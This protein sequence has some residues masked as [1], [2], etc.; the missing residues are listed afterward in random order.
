MRAV[1]TVRLPLQ[2]GT[3]SLWRAITYALTWVPAIALIV[4]AVRSVDYLEFD[5]LSLVILS[6]AA[7]G[8]ALLVGILW[9]IEV[10]LLRKDA[11]RLRA[12]DAV[13]DRDSVRIVGGVHHGLTL[14]IS[15]PEL[16]DLA[17]ETREEP[18]SQLL[19]ILA[20]RG[21]RRRIDSL[22]IGKDK[23]RRV[24]AEAFDDGERDSLRAL[25]ETILA[26]RATPVRDDRGRRVADEVVRCP[27]CGAAQPA[28]EA[29]EATCAHCGETVRIPDD[30]RGRLAAHRLLP[31]DRA[32]YQAL[33]RKLTSQPG[34]GTVNRITLA[35][36][37]VAVLAWPAVLLAAF[38]LH[39]HGTATADRLALL[40]AAELL[41]V[42]S[43][44]GLVRRLL[45][46]RAAL[47]LFALAYG[48]AP[49]PAPD[50]PPGCRHCAAPLA[51]GAGTSIARCGYCG[52]DNILGIDLRPIADPLR[53][54]RTTLEEAAAT[55]RRERARWTAVA[56]AS[57]AGVAAAAGA[58]LLALR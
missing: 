2:V 39:H 18:R 29:A 26:V 49:P 50:S 38:Y 7:R 34:A 23:D 21:G 16:A 1:S 58:L 12:S 33:I 56:L 13:I 25:H 41:A 43:L 19:Y 44:A 31:A 22:V 48:A 47:R 17:I 5:A 35:V 40:A 9:C 52:T 27:G 3:S 32:R 55:R 46:E 15:D 24:L 14:R 10:H 30:V 45:A 53:A 20:D 4:F 8:I 37:V 11:R 6:L 42:L 57:A 28:S 51:A 54:Q 36:V